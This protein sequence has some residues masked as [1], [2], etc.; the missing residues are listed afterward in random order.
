MHVSQARAAGSGF[1]RSAAQPLPQQPQQSSSTG[2]KSSAKQQRMLATNPLQSFS[3]PSRSPRNADEE[4]KRYSA[5]GVA[6]PQPPSVR[7]K[8]PPAEWQQ[9]ENS[10][11]TTSARAASG[12]Y[13]AAAAASS[14][15]VTGSAIDSGA[16]SGFSGSPVAHSALRKRTAAS[17]SAS[18]LSTFASAGDVGLYPPSTEPMMERRAVASLQTLSQASLKPYRL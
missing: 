11:P 15:F 12:K 13:T 16:A 9:S 5:A 10:T 18:K 8:K 2:V 17:V 14:R 6:A 4:S 1:R 7:G 3:T